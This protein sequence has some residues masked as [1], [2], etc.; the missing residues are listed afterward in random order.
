MD[1][2]VGIIFIL[3][4][5]AYRNI[6]TCLRLPPRPGGEGTECFITFLVQ[7]KQL[8]AQDTCGNRNDG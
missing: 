1:N 4:T 7:L 3:A 8:G 6:G 5:L 2:V